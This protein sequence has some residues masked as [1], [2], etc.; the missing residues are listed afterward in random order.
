MSGHGGN[1]YNYYE[2]AGTFPDYPPTNRVAEM[3]SASFDINDSSNSP[4]R[5][6]YPHD[7]ITNQPSHYH[8]SSSQTLTGAVPS[9]SRRKDEFTSG[10]SLATLSDSALISIPVNLY[11]S[12]VF[13][14]SKRDSQFSSPEIQKQLAKI[15]SKK[16]YKPY[17]VAIVT[18][19]Q[20][21]G[22]ILSFVF[23]FNNTGSYIQTQPQFNILIGPS[24]EVSFAFNYA[25]K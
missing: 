10:D 3:S 4:Y 23:N 19:L 9:L 21:V 13:C 24:T 2:N 12:F 7:P 20:L 16:P 1:G 14:N 5:Q 18:L 17:F 22:L 15:T 6:T 8:Q 25:N 11:F